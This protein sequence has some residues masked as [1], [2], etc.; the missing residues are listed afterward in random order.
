MSVMGL[1]IIG[2]VFFAFGYGVA[3]QRYKQEE[4]HERENGQQKR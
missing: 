3:R 1:L 4:V 2:L